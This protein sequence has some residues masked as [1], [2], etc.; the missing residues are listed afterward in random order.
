MIKH[1]TQQFNVVTCRPARPACVK[2]KTC[3]LERERKRQRT[4]TTLKQHM[5]L[6]KKENRNII[7]L[8]ANEQT[9]DPEGI[10]G[11]QPPVTGMIY[12][13]GGMILEL[14]IAW[15]TCREKKKLFCPSPL[16][17]DTHSLRNSFHSLSVFLLLV[18]LPFD[19]LILGHCLPPT[20]AP[21]G[22]PTS[23]LRNHD[24]QM[25]VAQGLFFTACSLQ[26]GGKSLPGSRAMKVQKSSFKLK[27]ALMKV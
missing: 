2:R 8:S 26:S 5:Y 7:F 10:Q 11:E 17:P 18:S 6:L 25:T 13:E 21:L 24:F 12:Q 1:S 9:S 14:S 3:C 23:N 27:F 15:R 20:N 16:H 4:Q 19:A 22:K